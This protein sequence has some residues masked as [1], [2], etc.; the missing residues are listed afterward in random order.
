[1]RSQP[2]LRDVRDHDADGLAALIGAAYADYPGCVLDL[3]GVDADLTAPASAA[4]RTGGRWWVL[5][6]GTRIVG[7]VGVGPRGA[8]GSVE[9]KRL[10]LDADLRGRGLATELIDRV[11]DHAAGLGA[12]R[13]E[14]WSDSRFAAAHHRYERSGYR[15]EA[16]TRDLHDPSNTTEYHFTRLLVP[17]QPSERWEHA[18][19]GGVRRSQ[20]HALPDGVLVRSHDDDTEVEVETDGAHAVR[21][22]KLAA[23]SV[24]A[25]NSDGHGRWW[26]AGQR[27]PDL[28]GCLDV[29]LDMLPW[30]Y[31][32]LARRLPLAVGDGAEPPV[33][34][35]TIGAA[36]EVDLA[37][38]SVRCERIGS[39]RWRLTT[40]REEIEVA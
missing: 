12:T 25:A 26:R 37:R 32:L 2:V 21:R 24:A 19:P 38:G 7:S 1:M 40:D 16:D 22:V 3:P 34:V 15:R 11:H 39:H 29:V 23:G 20:L 6:D 36:G 13:V 33:V 14:L 8:D 9:L 27:E 35:A 17:A 5:V 18:G 30:T 31:R 4:G 28:D 10:Y